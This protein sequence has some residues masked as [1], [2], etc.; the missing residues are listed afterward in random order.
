MLELIRDE[1][2]D[3]LIRSLPNSPTPALYAIR[4]REWTCD[5]EKRPLL[6]KRCPSL[7]ALDTEI[8]AIKERLN[9]I[10][11]EAHQKWGPERA[12]HHQ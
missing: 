6:T 9:Q 8:D 11:K 1:R 10:Q 5:D 12:E 2:P 3:A 4:L 7:L